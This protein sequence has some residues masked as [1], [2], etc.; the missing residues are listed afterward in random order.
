MISIN[1]P[2]VQNWPPP[3]LLD[4]PADDAKLWRY[5][6]LSKFIDLLDTSTL[7]LTRAA[8]FEDRFE[9]SYPKANAVEPQGD[10]SSRL[11]PLRRKLRDWYYVNCWHMNEYEPAAMWDLYAA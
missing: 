7:Y 2:S 9:G 11:A 10:P 4:V 8:L 5:M 3:P 6:D 1:Q